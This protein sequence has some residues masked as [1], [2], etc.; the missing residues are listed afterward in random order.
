MG[1]KGFYSMNGMIKG[2]DNDENITYC[3]YPDGSAEFGCGAALF[4]PDKS[5]HIARWCNF[6]GISGGKICMYNAG[7]CSHMG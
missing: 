7:C 4:K 6:L 1:L 3:I 5:G 2:V